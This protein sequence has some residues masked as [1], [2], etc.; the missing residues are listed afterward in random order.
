MRLRQKKPAHLHHEEW[1]VHRPKAT[2]ALIAE[3]L[4]I[5][6]AQRPIRRRIPTSSPKGM[7]RFATNPPA[8]AQMAVAKVDSDG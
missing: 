8:R 1:L 3:A 7:D 2:D 5:L 4:Q 6:T